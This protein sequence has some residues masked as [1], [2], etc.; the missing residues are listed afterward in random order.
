MFNRAVAIEHACERLI[1]S[2]AV[3]PS[4]QIKQLEPRAAK[5][6]LPLQKM[7]ANRAA[8]RKCRGRRRLMK[9]LL[10]LSQALIMDSH[11]WRLSMVEMSAK[12]AAPKSAAPL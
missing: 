5:A 7:E 1:V 2:M 12:K 4:P 8:R 11:L 10:T 9:P 6:D 3:N